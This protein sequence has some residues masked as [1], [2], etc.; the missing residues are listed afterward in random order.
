MGMTNY[1]YMATVKQW[2]H[3][4]PKGMPAQVSEAVG[5]GTHRFSAAWG[6]S[7]GAEH[8]RHTAITHIGIALAAP[9]PGALPYNLIDLLLADTRGARSV[10]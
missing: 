1:A 3:R 4:E 10:L 8:E 2:T 7:R 6:G 5:A 9:V